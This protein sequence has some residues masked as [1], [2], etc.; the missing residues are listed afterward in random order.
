MTTTQSHPEQRRIRTINVVALVAFTATALFTILFFGARPGALSVWLYFGLATTYLIGYAL[1]IVLNRRGHHDG[2]AVLVLAAGLA[3]LVAVSFTVGFRSGP[4]VFMVTIGMAAVLVTRISDHGVRWSFVVLSVV[5]YAVLVVIDPPVSASIEE[6]WI[7]DVLIVATYAGMIGFV[8]GVIW[9]QRLLADRV[10]DALA[11][12]NELSER[13]L[14]N[15]LP[16]DIA[17]R[18]KT[19]E[20]PIADRK[21]EVT[22]LFADIVGST[23]VAERLSP[24]ELV[25][26]LDGVFS[27]FDDIADEFGLEKIKTV[28]DSYF[29]VAGLSANSADHASAAAD[30]ALSMREQLAHH[31][32]PNM[33]P[34]HMRFGLHTGPVIAGVIGKRKFSYDLWGD[35]VNTGSRMESTGEQGMIQVSEQVRDRLKDRYDFES[36]GY[37]EIKGKGGLMTFELVRKRT[38]VG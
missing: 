16:A 28:G 17:E 5:T 35:T 36:R 19:N 1:T 29:A 15:I 23:S 4:A 10:Q 21:P 34:V 3:N 6:T 7:Q 14:L 11:D 25:T 8:V 2:A 18:L 20:Y 38:S 9:Y 24:N 31:E 22:V 37:V 27:S 12:A 13:L 33:G 30:A 26:T 32:F